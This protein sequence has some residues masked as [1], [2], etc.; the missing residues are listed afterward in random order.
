MP[1]WKAAGLVSNR[2]ELSAPPTRIPLPPPA[3]HLLNHLVYRKGR[4]IQHLRIGSWN[5]R[6]NASFFVALVPFGQIPGKGA[7]ISSDSF[8][9]QL[10]ISSFGPHFRARCQ[11]NLERGIREHDGPHVAPVGDQAGRLPE[12]AL[13]LEERL[14]DGWMARN[15]GRLVA[16]GLAADFVRNILFIQ[17]NTSSPE[18]DRHARRYASQLPFPILP[19]LEG[20]QGHKAVK[21]TTLQI[22]EAKRLGHAARHSSLARGRRPIDGD[23]R[24]AHDTILFQ[25]SKKPGKVL[26]THPGSLIVTG[27]PPNSASEK[28]IA[29]R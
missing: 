23:D 13:A 11:E 17:H 25:A 19:R 6:R 14:P 29:M 15:L 10:L 9:D 21:R 16:H 12:G 4:G 27:T 2:T 22:M 28:L 8:V 5:E 18:G 7:K 3:E 20:P 1:A 26:A 24:C